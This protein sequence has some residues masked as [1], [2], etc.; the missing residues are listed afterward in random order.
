MREVPCRGSDNVRC[1]TFF[2]ELRCGGLKAPVMGGVE[3]GSLSES[4]S[5]SSHFDLVREIPEAM[6]PRAIADREFR[7][8]PGGPADQGRRLKI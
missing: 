8:S 6:K 7:Q 3:P 4:V 1:D 2:L 5:N